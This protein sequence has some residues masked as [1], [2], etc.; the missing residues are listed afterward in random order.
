[1]LLRFYPGSNL[2]T[3]RPGGAAP[4][5]VMM[6][7]AE[8]PGELD[9]MAVVQGEPLMQQ[10][11]PPMPPADHPIGPTSTPAPALEVEDTNTNNNHKL[12]DA[13]KTVIRAQLDDDF[14]PSEVGELDSQLTQL[15]NLLR[16]ARAGVITSSMLLLGPRGSGKS[17]VGTFLSN[18]SLSLSLSLSLVRFPFARSYSHRA[19]LIINVSIDR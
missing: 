11:Q 1:M 10:Q 3:M 4:R 16:A 18:L 15:C 2:G 13:I 6:P 9:S 8:G 7:M 17:L 19:L 5:S 12:I 14:M